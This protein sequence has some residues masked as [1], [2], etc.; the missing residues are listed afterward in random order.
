MPKA[1]SF[2]L[3]S[4]LCVC[5]CVCG[6]VV[7]YYTEEEEEEE[8]SA[9]ARWESFS[10]ILFSTVRNRRIKA[11]TKT[12]GCAREVHSTRKLQGFSS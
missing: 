11:D 6:T 12:P 1:V 10:R 8:H 2:T 4:L 9:D 3:P 5:V 7:M